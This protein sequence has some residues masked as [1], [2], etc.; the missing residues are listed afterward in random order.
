MI[1]RFL[2]AY[3]L[4]FLHEGCHYLTA[5]MLFVK[6]DGIFLRPWGSSLRLASVSSPKNEFLIAAA[7]PLFHL[8]LL[9]VSLKSEFFFFCNMAMLFANIVPVLPLDGGRMLRAFLIDVLPLKKANHYSRVVG[10]LFIFLIYGVSFFLLLKCRMVSPLFC[11]ALFL[12]FHRNEEERFYL[13]TRTFTEKKEK[14]GNMYLVSGE[15]CASLIC[16]ELFRNR[17]N[18]F[19]LSSSKGIYGVLSERTILEGVGKW[20]SRNSLDKI[21]VN[22]VEKKREI[23]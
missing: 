11:L 21:F 22:M 14:C 15:G 17:E 12:S 16:S 23:G 5:K 2:M 10:G 18:F 3:L 6:T 8:V 1:E 19:F 20:G 4:S 7:G 13:Y 9:P